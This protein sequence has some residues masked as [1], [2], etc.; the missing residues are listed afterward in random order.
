LP[1]LSLTPAILLLFEYVFLNEATSVNGVLG[2]LL[3]SAGGFWLG[4]SSQTSGT[5]SRWLVF[6]P[7]AGIFTSIAAMWSISSS[8]DKR[9]VRAA[10]PLIYGATMKATIAIGAALVWGL[11]VCSSRRSSNGTCKTL[12]PSTGFKHVV[13][14]LMWWAL[15]MSAYFFQ[16]SANS[17]LPSSYLSG[18][19]RAG[20]LFGLFLGRLLFQEDIGRK[21]TP[22]SVMVLGVCFLAAK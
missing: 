18:I 17:R 8:F 1:F 9:G 12:H 19:R 3:I 11:K 6:P 14:M 5:K 16:L 20:C 2:V 13:L 22:V 15:D 10:S 21:M 7:G 4:R